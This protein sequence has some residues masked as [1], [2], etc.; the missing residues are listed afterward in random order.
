MRSL[1]GCILSLSTRNIPLDDS[2]HKLSP[3]NYHD[4]A[5]APPPTR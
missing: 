1:T 5:Q 3:G 2:A 4:D